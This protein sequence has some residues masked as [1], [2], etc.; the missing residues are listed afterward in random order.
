MTALKSAQA[1][2]LSRLNDNQTLHSVD[3]RKLGRA[4][5]EVLLRAIDEMH[6]LVD[7]GVIEPTV[8]HTF[9]FD[10]IQDAYRALAD[11]QNVGKIVVSIP[12]AYRF[13]AREST[14]SL[15]PIA[16]IGM[17][18]RFARAQNV[19]ELWEALAG[20]QDLIEPVTRWPLPQRDERSGRPFCDQGGLLRDIDAFDPMFF[21][22]SGSEAQAM[23][24]QQRL[25][26]EEAWRALEDAGHAGAGIKGRRC[27]VYVG[28]ANG[29]YARLFDERAP[30]QAFWGNAGSVI[31]AR[32][33]YHL[34]LQG[35]AVAID[36]AC[37]S[38]LVALH[39]ACESLRAGE[40][41][42]ALAGGVFVQSTDAFYQQSNR[43]GMLSPNGRCYSFDARADGFVPGEGVGAIVL[44]RLSQAIADGD[45]VHGVIRA[46]GMNQDGATNG[47]TAPSARSQ[48]RLERDVYRR[49]G[50]DPAEIQVVE[51]HG[52]G[53]ALGDPI[54][55]GALAEV[56]ASKGDRGER[57]ALGSIKS[58]LGHTATAAGMAG[59]IKL[60]L[61]LRHRQIPPS[62]HFERGNPRIDFEQ[63]PF[64]VNTGLKAWDVP[65]GRE[66]LAAVSSFGFS[67]TNAH[68]VIGEAPEV[69]PLQAPQRPAYLLVLS[70]ATAGQLRTQV[71]QLVAHC[72]RE[73]VDVG[74][75]SF[76]LMTGRRHMEHRLACV[77]SDLADVVERLEMWLDQGRAPRVAS[78]M[79]E[80]EKN[81]AAGLSKVGERCIA[82]YLQASN[83]EVIVEA[84]STLAELF[85]QGVELEWGRLF[86]GGK[87]R[88]AS[89]PTYP[90]AR[91][92]YWVPNDAQRAP[93]PSAAAKQRPSRLHPLID[94]NSSDLSEQRYSTVLTGEAFYLRDH[95]VRGQR[96]MPG[97]VQLE[98]ARLLILI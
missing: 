16:V 91:E 25:F 40:A 1:I 38:S 49:F 68:A 17:S 30:A 9:P 15:E 47:I 55:F 79:R 76:T 70:A 6:R 22:I 73:A 81:G 89:L 23:D 90:F 62:L 71:E 64:Y 98:W 75:M 36:T 8:S 34:D 65:A 21:N 87:Y 3:L 92:R 97:V 61:A 2:D 5:P 72:R 31:P 29:D 48:A 57:C 50:I 19:D 44:K 94:R 18:G 39:L 54:E 85:A 82:E 14:A 53:T 96:V 46:S 7:A 45:H 33:A 88:R 93:A 77:A 63:S 24:P 51:A 20:A 52:T 26:L 12:E 95:V 27:A 35:P 69:A 58:N 4:Q 80:P 56:F 78:G 10:R 66:R 74:A 67:G 13:K 42:L 43:A 83:R 41:E 60:L 84:L 11:R 59:V 32:I 37:S 86:A 28:C